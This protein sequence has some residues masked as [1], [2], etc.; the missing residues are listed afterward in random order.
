MVKCAALHSVPVHSRPTKVLGVMG[1]LRHLFGCLR[2]LLIY[3]A[4]LV[5]KNLHII[6]AGCNLCLFDL[7]DGSTRPECMPLLQDIKLNKQ[8]TKCFQ[9]SLELEAGTRVNRSSKR[10]VRLSWSPLGVP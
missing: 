1:V 9:D 10:G 7:I 3:T 5:T 2:I 4:S 6:T 8:T